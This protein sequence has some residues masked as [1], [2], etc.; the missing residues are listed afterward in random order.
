MK[1]L[2]NYIVIIFITN[3][4][5]FSN[6]VNSKTYGTLDKTCLEFLR[7]SMPVRCNNVLISQR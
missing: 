2:L 3:N 1:K 4:Y 5:L 7:L 6:K